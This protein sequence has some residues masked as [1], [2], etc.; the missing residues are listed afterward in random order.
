MEQGNE[1]DRIIVPAAPP[2]ALGTQVE[3][4][5]GGIDDS[6][7]QETYYI[8]K[9]IE[10]AFPRGKK[11]II[12]G[13]VIGTGSIFK[14][15][16]F[17]LQI[18]I[19]SPLLLKDI[20]LNVYS[21]RDKIR[22]LQLAPGF[23]LSKDG[24]TIQAEKLPEADP[25]TTRPRTPPPRPTTPPRSPPPLGGSRKKKNTKRKRRSIHKRSLKKRLSKKRLSRKNRRRQ[26]KSKRR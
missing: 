3:I 19:T 22:D 8:T 7:A 10:K 24:R 9:R 11:R 6:Q 15:N 18:E 14:D 26:N 5:Y 1:G 13:T 12:Y 21:I 4:E 23:Q 25:S 20:V 2:S 16:T 17:M